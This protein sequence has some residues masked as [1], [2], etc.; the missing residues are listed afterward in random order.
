MERKPIV[1]GKL[2]LINNVL[3]SIPIYLLY[4]IN[5]PKFVIRFEVVAQT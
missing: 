2:I 1:G 4:V 3:H 5:T